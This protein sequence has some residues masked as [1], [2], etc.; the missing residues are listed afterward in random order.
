[1]KL[2]RSRLA[3]GR[4]LLDL[5]RRPGPRVL[6][7]QEAP[8]V[9][10]AASAQSGSHCPRRCTIFNGPANQRRCKMGFGEEE[11]MC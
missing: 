2:F 8:H 5:C 4:R 10:T 1:M 11:L 7:A 9:G 3:W 6:S